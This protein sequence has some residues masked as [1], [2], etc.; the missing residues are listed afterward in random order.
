MGCGVNKKKAYRAP[1]VVLVPFKE[2]IQ[3][4]KKW[5]MGL[6]LPIHTRV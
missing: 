5:C 4:F 2:G 6:P 3:I 1:S